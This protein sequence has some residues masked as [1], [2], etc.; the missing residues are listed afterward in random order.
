MDRSSLFLHPALYEPFGLVVL[1]A[2]QRGCCLVLADIPSLR[3]LWQ[4]A[5]VFVDP[6]DESSWI[7]AL[8]RLIENS[9][10]RNRFAALARARS[11]HFGE[12][13][14]RARYIDVYRVLLNGKAEAA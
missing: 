2:A 11:A 12:L 5:A 4:G 1:E 8:N 9:S 14:T 10:E 6:R 13:S 3:E 7:S